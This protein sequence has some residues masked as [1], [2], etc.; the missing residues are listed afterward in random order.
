[1]GFSCWKRKRP[2]EP[3]RQCTSCYWPARLSTFDNV[4]RLE[5]DAEYATALINDS[6]RRANCHTVILPY[7]TGRGLWVKINIIPDKSNIRYVST[8]YILARSTSRSS[9]Q[10]QTHLVRP[11]AVS[12]QRWGRCRAYRS[13]GG[14]PYRPPPFL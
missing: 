5:V 11:R 6:T 14:L 2:R 4:V 3:E 7:G 13:Q 8:E 12:A 9:R 10:T 1:M